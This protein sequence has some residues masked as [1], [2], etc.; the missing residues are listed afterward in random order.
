MKIALGADHG[1][2]ELKT[3]VAGWL[4][5]AGHEV[6]DLGAPSYDGSDDYAD[7]LLPSAKRWPPARRSAAS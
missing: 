6:L 4:E 7:L 1:G 2:Y 3:Q 5:E